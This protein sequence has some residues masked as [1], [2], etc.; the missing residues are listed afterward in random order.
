MSLKLAD[1]YEDVARMHRDGS[2]GVVATVVSAGGSTPR[3][4]G[5]KMVVYPDGRTLGTVGG[6]AVESSVIDRALELCGAG[7]PVLL[8][9]D[10]DDD[11]GAICGGRMEVFLEPVAPGPS[12]LVVGG[13]HVGQAV[14]RAARN[15]GF[16]VD[17]VD[18]RPEVVTP[19]RFPFADRRFVG[20]TELLGSE[21]RL[22][23]SAFVVVVT[24]GH[25][26]DKDWVEAFAGSW[27]AYLGMIGSET[28]VRKTFEQ[29][30]KDGVPEDL[31]GRIHA[32][33]G[34]D[35]GAETP[36]EIAV[37]IVAE[38]IAVRHGVTDTAMLK[39]KPDFKGRDRE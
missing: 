22:D 20:G 30:V 38:M 31:L 3:G 35:I 16:R 2:A 12:V 39:D 21:I 11:S 8:S 23:P 29:M 27:P 19:E 5:A 9:F 4:A 32:P 17:V 14:A 26:F 24:R 36:D 37:S 33:I 10:L 7:G 34:L 28:K 18:D 13:G 6:G 15:A 1:I 25:R